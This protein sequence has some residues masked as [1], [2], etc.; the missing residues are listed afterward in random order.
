MK[1]LGVSSI[2]ELEPKHVTQLTRLVPVAQP[3]PRAVR[4]RTAAASKA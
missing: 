1:L 4:T 3:A 2:A